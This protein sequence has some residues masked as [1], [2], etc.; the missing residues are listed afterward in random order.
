MNDPEPIVIG[1][2]LYRYRVL[3]SDGEVVDFE[4]PWDSSRVRSAMIAYHWPSD[5]PTTQGHAITGMACL[6][7]AHIV[8][9][10]VDRY[11]E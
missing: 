6:G 8:P 3:F 4:A 11:I 9:G 7:E 1:V 5:K 2:T 10:N